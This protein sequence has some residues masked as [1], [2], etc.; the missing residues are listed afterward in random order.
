MRPVTFL[1][2]A[3]PLSAILLAQSYFPS[4]LPS[5]QPTLS[6]I[7]QARP[8][9]RGSD[10]ERMVTRAEIRVLP[11]DVA[12]ERIN[13]LESLR[14]RVTRAE[15]DALKLSSS[16]P[17]MRE[18]LF[19]QIEIMQ[20]LLQFV[21][22][23]QSDQGKSPAAIEVERHLNDIEGRVNCNACHMRVVAS[24]GEKRK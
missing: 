19:R 17:A 20:A 11:L 7:A 24:S 1:S 18:H 3:F 5:L 2:V 21:E 13:E 4:H 10:G 15:S 16:A 23:E 6:Q 22:R 8:D 12:A 14:G 9:T